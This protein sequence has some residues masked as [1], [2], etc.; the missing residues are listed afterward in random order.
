MI[1]SIYAALL[2]IFFVALS[3]RTLLLR[4]RLKIAIGD[5]KNPRM[6]RAMRTHANFAEYAPL[7]LL[8]IAACEQ[9]AAPAIVVHTMGVMLL[10]GRLVHA[11]GVSKEAEVFVYRVAG[12]AL[13]FT[14]YLAAAG[15]ILLRVC[16]TGG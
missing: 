10:L 12:M 15:Y 2:G 14:C 16:L 6:L 13:T 8:L 1:W 7:G 9:R 5:G 4:R 11:Y 3:V